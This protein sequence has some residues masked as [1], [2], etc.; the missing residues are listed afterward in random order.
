VIFSVGCA[1][2]STRNFFDQSPV[3]RLGLLPIGIVCLPWD[4]VTSSLPRD[5]EYSER[6]TLDGKCNMTCMIRDSAPAWVSA[7]SMDIKI[8]SKNFGSHL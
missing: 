3:H 6:F 2:N 4:L 1:E 8:Q 7:E 5:T